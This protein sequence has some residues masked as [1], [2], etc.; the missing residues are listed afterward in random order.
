M[1][2]TLTVSFAIS[3][4]CFG[5]KQDNLKE[6]DQPSIAE[7]FA[8]HWSQHS[9]GLDIDNNGKG[10]LG[11]RTY[12]Y[13]DEAPP[14]C[15]TVDGH[16]IISGGFATISLE[17]EKNSPYRAIGRVLTSTDP[18]TLP[19]GTISIR[20]DPRDDL[21]YLSPFGGSELRLCGEKA[22]KGKCGA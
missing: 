21:L 7:S 13:C 18:E 14:P 6:E 22:P 15:D 3:L 4:A 2:R 8:G 20:V 11:W 9:I 10:E 19:L 16:S 17:V 1:F 5:C 12:K